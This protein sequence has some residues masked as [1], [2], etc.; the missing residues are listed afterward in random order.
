[1]PSLKSIWII[2]IFYCNGRINDENWPYSDFIDVRIL[3]S[4]S[5]SLKV[6]S[7]KFYKDQ[8]YFNGD[9]VQGV[10]LQLK[11]A[12]IKQWISNWTGS[13]VQMTLRSKF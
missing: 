8:Q 1:M 9:K 4:F 13:N 10:I 5:K 6:V 7:V 3:F 11:L 12:N 2:E